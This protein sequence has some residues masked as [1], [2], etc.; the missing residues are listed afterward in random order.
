MFPDPTNGRWPLVTIFGGSGF[1]GR[2]LVRTLARQEW[3]IRVACR[4][5]SLAGFLQPLGRVGQIQVVQA[6]LRYPESVAASLEGAD[7]V[8]NLVGVL[9]A[10]GAQTFESVQAQGA[11]CVAEAARAAGIQRLIH[12]SALGA[13]AASSSV[14][15]RT[16]AAGEEAV[17]AAAPGAIV[18]RPSIVF[19]PEDDFFN[20]FAEMARVSPVLP[21]IGGGGTRFQPVFVG[22]VAEAVVRGLEG[23]AREGAIFELGGPQVLTFRELLAFVCRTTHRRRAFAPLPWGAA[24]ALALA[25]R[26]LTALGVTPGWAVLTADQVELLKSDNVVSEAARR[27]QR[28]LE[29]LGL[30]PDSIEAIVPTYLWRYRKAGQYE[31]GRAA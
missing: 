18:L 11:A 22:D 2:H 27:D 16:K 9:R 24:R 4:R 23:R 3:R 7:A 14:Y 21:L 26:P 12:L 17:R 15:A 19:G 6:N 30:E 8:V 31:R 5:P 1:I 10:S 29:G 28:T 13:D 20:R 25:T